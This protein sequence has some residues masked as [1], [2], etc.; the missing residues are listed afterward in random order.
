MSKVKGLILCGGTGTRLRP[1]TYYFQKTM[2]PIGSKQKP[3]LEY[4]VRL[5]GFHK[6]TDLAFLINYKGEQIQ[7]YFNHGERFGVKISYVQDDATLKG[8][9]GAVLNAYKRGVIHKDETILVYYGDILT[10]MNLTEM[11]KRHTKRK[12]AAT[13]GLASGFTVRVGVAEMDKDGKIKGFVEKPTLEKPVSVGILA[14]DGKVL[15]VME[16]LAAKGKELD[17]MGDVVP[18]LIKKNSPV[19]GYLSKA[20]WYDVGSTE[21]YEKLSPKIVDEA[22]SFLF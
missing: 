4:V 7:N 19:F 18:F 8:T 12:A 16:R 9:G 10:N 11:L 5:L 1:I 13:I 15:E 20:F 21:A 17:L 22:L 14:L 3:L 6:V 2:I